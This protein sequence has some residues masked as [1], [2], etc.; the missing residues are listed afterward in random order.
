MTDR[1]WKYTA[2]IQGKPKKAGTQ[3]RYS[4][5]E[6]DKSLFSMN[7]KSRRHNYIGNY[8]KIKRQGRI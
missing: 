7:L 6:L 5:K 2:T 1:L 8:M 3:R 4:K